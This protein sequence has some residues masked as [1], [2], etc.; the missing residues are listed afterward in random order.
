MEPCPQSPRLIWRF[1]FSEH[2]G[3]GLRKKISAALDGA[4]SMPDPQAD[5]YWR[6]QGLS[7]HAYE[8]PTDAPAADLLA[9]CRQQAARV[10]PRWKVTPLESSGAFSGYLEAAEPPLIWAGFQFEPKLT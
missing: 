7:V 5:Y 2:P 10:A 6:E 8:A 1:A 3:D 4:M 9:R